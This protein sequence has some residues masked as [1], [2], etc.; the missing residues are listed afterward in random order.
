MS[1]LSKLFG[2][3]SSDKQNIPLL[4]DIELNYIGLK[5]EATLKKMVSSRD[6]E[7]LSAIIIKI[8]IMKG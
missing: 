7:K 8:T 6:Y 4:P 1:F 5:G 2:A 3:F